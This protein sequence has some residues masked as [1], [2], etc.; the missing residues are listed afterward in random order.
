MCSGGRSIGR[1]QHGSESLRISDSCF[2]F[3]SAFGCGLVVRASGALAHGGWIPVCLCRQCVFLCGS[4]GGVAVAS[5][6]EAYQAFVINRPQEIPFW[7]WLMTLRVVR[8]T[9]E[10]PDSPIS[11]PGQVSLEHHDL[12]HILLGVGVSREEEAFVVGWTM[13][14]DP[15][16]RSWHLSLFLWVARWL[17]PD[18]YRFR[19]QDIP[20]FYQGLAWGKSCPRLD[21]SQIDRS[22]SVEDLRVV[23]ALEGIPAEQ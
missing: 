4:F 19:K 20:V 12:I 13:G 10:N 5:L 8:S 1:L 6:E 2:E 7:V 18:P 23:V 14:N 15:K 9:M 17:Y 21:V 3:G 11:F 16:L 22:R